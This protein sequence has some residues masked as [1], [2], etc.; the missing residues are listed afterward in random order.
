MQEVLTGRNTL[1]IASI[2]VSSFS[3]SSATSSS[4]DVHS[5][6][7]SGWGLETAVN[8]TSTCGIA[9]RLRKAEKRTAP[10]GPQKRFNYKAS[11]L[12]VVECGAIITTCTVIMFGLYA[13]G[14]DS[15]I[16]GVGIATQ[17][18]TIAPLLIIARVGIA[19]NVSRRSQTTF[20]GPG[21]LE[22][23]VIRTE[24]TFDGHH[25]HS[26]P[27]EDSVGALSRNGS[28]QRKGAIGP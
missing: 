19:Q 12:I 23:N 28:V 22:I 4:H 20:R 6:G 2:A 21:P 25:M 13:S 14:K 8:L 11:M 24:D 7:L 16:V 5:Y 3:P 15:G 1:G 18:A 26:M 27:S 17:V 9:Y 10:L